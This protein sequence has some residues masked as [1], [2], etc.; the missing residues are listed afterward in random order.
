MDME[1]FAND[2]KIDPSQLDVEAATQVD[3]FFSWAEE[4]AHARGELDRS[5]ALLDLTENELALNIRKDP[6]EYG[7]AKVTEAAINATVRSH[8]GYKLCVS[9]YLECKEECALLD[10][11]VQAMEH[12]KRMIE[13]LITLHGQQYFAGPSVPRDL[14]SAFHEREEERSEDLNRRQKKRVR[15]S[16]RK[17]KKR[18]SDCEE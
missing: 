14:V 6:D 10:H 16:N 13:V 8:K 9:K 3:V 17:S 15:K 12:R 18:R 7:L 5:K 4:F 1:R 2:R 11:A